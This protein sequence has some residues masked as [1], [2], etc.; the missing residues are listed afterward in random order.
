MT[1][2]LAGTLF[3]ATL[4][5]ALVTAV[6]T[7]LEMEEEA[8][9]VDSPYSWLPPRGRPSSPLCASRIKLSRLLPVSRPTLSRLLPYFDSIEDSIVKHSSR[10]QNDRN[11]YC[12]L[13]V[14][15]AMAFGI[16]TANAAKTIFDKNCRRSTAMQSTRTNLSSLWLWRWYGDRGFE[17]AGQ[18]YHIAYGFVLT[19]IRRANN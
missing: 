8:M 10:S 14:V 13:W 2:S 12:F 6:G 19:V 1:P 7:R 11:I 9:G 15:I 5:A 18:A 3:I 16:T 4:G 17:S